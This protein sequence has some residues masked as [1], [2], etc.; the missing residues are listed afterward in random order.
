M[1]RSIYAVID[2]NVIVS[3]II[4]KTP[5]S[6][7]LKVLQAIGDGGFVPVYNDDILK[8]YIEVLSRPKFHVSPLRISSLLQEIENLGLRSHPT[9]YLHPMPDPKDRVFYEVS[10]TE[11]SYLVTGNQKH[12]PSEPK[13]VTPSEF[14]DILSQERAAR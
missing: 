10:L 7:T 3:A 12:F 14:L 6:P 8:E 11:G 1:S 13:V 2:T 4:T 9:P 5:L